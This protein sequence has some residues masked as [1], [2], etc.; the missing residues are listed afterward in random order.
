MNRVRVYHRQSFSNI[1]LERQRQR[2]GR[3]S[4][5]LQTI[6]QDA[7]KGIHKEVGEAN[8]PRGLVIRNALQK[9]FHRQALTSIPSVER[10]AVETQQVLQGIIAIGVIDDDRGGEIAP[11]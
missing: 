4:R 3:K 8:R 6:G 1:E 11:K 7:T 2:F 9:Q 10:I 5:V